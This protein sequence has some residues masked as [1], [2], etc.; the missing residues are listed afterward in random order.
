MDCYLSPLKCDKL[1][2][3]AFANLLVKLENN[4]SLTLEFRLLLTVLS[5]NKN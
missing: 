5:Q 1:A 4:V 2:A 3:G